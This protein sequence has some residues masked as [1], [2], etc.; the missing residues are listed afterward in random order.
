MMSELRILIVD[1]HA[2]IR[3]GI[4]GLLAERKEWVVCGEAADGV[5]AI[6]KAKTLVPDVVLMDVSMPRMDG[7]QAAKIFR[8]E[9]PNAK[10][11]IVSQNDPGVVKR[12]A[13]EA[14]V[15]SYVAKSALALELV[16][17]LERITF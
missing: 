13:A 1:D 5:E 10:I 14:G 12:Q 8:R 2:T 9:A 15:A 6:E 11:V 3:E 17:T 7:I 4:R 16:P